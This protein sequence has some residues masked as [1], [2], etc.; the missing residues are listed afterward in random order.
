VLVTL[1]VAGGSAS[2]QSFDVRSG[3]VVR[4]G[5]SE[6]ADF[7]VPGDAAVSALHFSL[8]CDSRHCYLRV[9]DTGG[10]TL[11]NGQKVARAVLNVGDR[12]TAGQTTFTVC[13]E[14][15]PA[16]SPAA[17]EPAPPP[18]AAEPVPQPPE[19]APAPPVAAAVAVESAVA[20]AAAPQTAGELCRDL[21]LDEEAL[22]LLRPETTPGEFLSRL[23][24]KELFS[25]ALRFVGHWLAK[26]QAIRW[27]RDCVL[28]AAPGELPAPE[29]VAIEVV[30]RWLEDPT[31]ES[32]RAA[33]DAAEAAQY[34]GPA[35]WVAI[36]V[37]WSG[38]SIAP[39]GESVVPPSKGLMA[40]AISAGL[41]MAAAADPPQAG[42]RYRAM[43]DAGRQ[44]L[45][46][47][48]SDPV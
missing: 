26:P 37:F 45:R 19:V 18:V 46:S 8:T 33:Q 6:T 36:A 5:S 12:V 43:L 35:S 48:G 11:V 7:A 13:E 24:E 27:A 20:E 41:T 9:L 25:D 21:T 31:E 28:A 4:V 29:A 32:R 1:K 17:A 44:V 38:G 16:P 47:Q 30:N 2:G 34:N 15:E 14:A 23:I 3:Q 40:Q 22:K 42:A 39:V 10:D